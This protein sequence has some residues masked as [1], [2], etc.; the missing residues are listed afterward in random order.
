MIGIKLNR[1]QAE[2]IMELA[3]RQELNG[4]EAQPS[5]PMTPAEADRI[6]ANLTDLQRQAVQVLAQAAQTDAGAR[7]VYPGMTFASLVDF[8]QERDR[9]PGT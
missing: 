3:R 4:G 9:P 6:H 5:R 8:M 2:R 7:E 1:E